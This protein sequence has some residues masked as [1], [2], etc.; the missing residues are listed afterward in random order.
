MQR[1][2]H[3][4]GEQDVGIAL[5]RRI[6]H[7]QRDADRREHGQHRNSGQRISPIASMVATKHERRRREPRNIGAAIFA[8]VAI[9]SPAA[10]GASR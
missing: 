3:R 9:S 8:A 7:S 5:H 1:K 2:L 4:E 10:A 6:H